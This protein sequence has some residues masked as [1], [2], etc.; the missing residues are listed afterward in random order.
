[1]RR[2][3]H[4]G[5]AAIAA[6][7]AALGL[8]IGGCGG[9]PS[10]RAEAPEVPTGS[11][12]CKVA[13][14]QSNPLVTE[15]PASEK[16]N[17]E[18]RLATGAVA[19]AYS[20]CSMRLLP[21]CQIKGR[22]AFKRTTVATDTLEVRSEDELWAKLPLGAASLEGEL[23]RS[24]RISVQTTVG[25]Q[26]QL[27]DAR[28]SDVPAAGACRDATHVIGA[29]SVG[30]FRMRSGGTLT[31]SGGASSPVVGGG[32]ATASEESVMRS[33]GDPARCGEATDAAPHVDC[34]SPLQL[35][36]VPLPRT[37][38]ESADGPPG[39][40]RVSFVSGDA[41][42]EWEVRI[43]DKVL[44]KTPCKRWVDP[45]LPYA[46]ENDAWFWST[47]AVDLS[48][49]PSGRP[50]R[51]RAYGTDTT[52]MVVGGSVSGAGWIAFGLGLASLLRCGEE[53]SITGE[54][55][56][57]TPGYIAVPVGL[58]AFV[59]GIVYLLGAGPHSEVEPAP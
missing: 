36:L 1:M 9:A 50:L 25:G 23:S 54:K 45:T 37:A 22:Y 4:A 14:S 19:V 27:L 51:A 53:D 3:R 38:E 11:A 40:V 10:L 17:L 58:T 30:A 6:G 15:W 18:A 13:A 47:A 35:F 21:E 24:G 59:G 12:K 16:A 49:A 26:L 42:R 34:S 41:L 57:C 48:E 46:M 44:C 52:R 20:G 31:A 56:S 5:P 39:T 7:S 33:A 8:A 55:S 28:P 32:A 2:P 43:G 29:L